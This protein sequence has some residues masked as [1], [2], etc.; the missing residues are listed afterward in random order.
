MNLNPLLSFTANLRSHSNV[1]RSQVPGLF[2]L[3]NSPFFHND[4]KLSLKVIKGRGS[5]FAGRISSDLL[6]KVV[7]QDG[8]V[9]KALDSS[10]NVQMH[11]WVRSPLLVLFS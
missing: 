7:N 2:G 6:Y 11:A 5:V 3:V 10:S 4:K 1:S 8:R 9:V